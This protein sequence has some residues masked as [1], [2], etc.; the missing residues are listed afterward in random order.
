LQ[1]RL[2]KVE[3]LRDQIGLSADPAQRVA[4]AR[5]EFPTL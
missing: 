4:F 1:H 5:A 3:Q 2:R